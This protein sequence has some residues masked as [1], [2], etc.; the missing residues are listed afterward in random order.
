MNQLRS[1]P[2]S[3]LEPLLINHLGNKPHQY[4]IAHCVWY[5]ACNIM[6][7]MI[8]VGFFVLHDVLYDLGIMKLPLVILYTGSVSLYIQDNGL[9]WPNYVL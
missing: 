2:I 9:L 4:I 7:L 8:T 6:L 1:L 5:G 3:H